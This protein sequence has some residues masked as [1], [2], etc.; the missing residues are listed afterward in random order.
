MMSTTLH[1]FCIYFLLVSTLLCLTCLAKEDI[2][3]SGNIITSKL[4]GFF[5]VVILFESLRPSGLV[6]SML[7]PGDRGGGGG[8]GGRLRGTQLYRQEGVNEAK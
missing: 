8:G 5:F 4:S 2:E 6:A 7:N 1:L 3:I